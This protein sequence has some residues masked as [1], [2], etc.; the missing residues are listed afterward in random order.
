M[1]PN[2]Q[3]INHDDKDEFRHRS[4]CLLFSF[5]FKKYGTNSGQNWVNEI[6][7][8]TPLTDFGNATYRGFQ[9]GLYSNGSNYRPK[10]HNAAG[11]AL[12]KGIK[13]L[14][15]E[16]KRD[17]KSGTIVW[18]SI[19]MS[20]TTQETQAFLLR[21]QTFPAKNP[22][23]TLVDG[24][25]GGEDI[26]RI[27][28]SSASYW[29]AVYKRLSAVNLSP[30]QVQVIWFKEAE[31]RPTD[32]AFA[33]YPDAL[34]MKYKEVMQILKAKFPNLK[35]VYLSSRIY[36]GYAKTKQNPEPFAWYTGWTVKRLI[37]DQIKGDATLNYSGANPSA[38]WLS[39]G[40]YLWANGTTPRSDGLTWVP[41]D[42]QADGTHPSVA[43]RQKVAEMLLHFFSNDDTA[44][45]W[46]L[47][48]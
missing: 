45:P 17:E 18:L 40:P 44:K 11:L 4:H 20:N 32:T 15:S 41:A 31:K 16:G 14:N 35:L 1:H 47:K 7:A 38:A 22:K 34:K 26:N 5:A 37:E 24:A 12:A 23:L 3:E 10:A 30:L 39:W 48:P 9:G 6:T 43:G 29:R 21:M 36:A 28:D 13:P 27:N 2:Q 33:T 19:G 8:S 46:F 25:V 42:Y